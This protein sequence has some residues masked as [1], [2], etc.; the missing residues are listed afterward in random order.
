MKPISEISIFTFSAFVLGLW[1][2]FAWVLLLTNLFVYHFG[3]DDKVL[4]VGFV[5][6]GIL[7]TPMV[8]FFPYSLKMFNLSKSTTRIAG[9]AAWAVAVPVL[10]VGILLAYLISTLHF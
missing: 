9:A 7:M 4:L 5:T 3:I 2:I 1:S 6:V 8:I 10:L